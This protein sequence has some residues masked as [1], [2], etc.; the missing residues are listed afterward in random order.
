[1]FLACLGFYAGCV[2]RSYS[3][4]TRAGRVSSRDVPRWDVPFITEPN[5]YNFFTR[6]CFTDSDAT[7]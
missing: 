7:M 5:F 6:S 2:L 4:G 3:T 1:L